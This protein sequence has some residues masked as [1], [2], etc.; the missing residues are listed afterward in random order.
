MSNIDKFRIPINKSVVASLRL[1]CV[2]VDNVEYSYVFLI[3]ICKKNL[4]QLKTNTPSL[5]Y[6]I[7]E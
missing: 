1:I 5:E 3:H 2:I 4:D 6:L 7:S